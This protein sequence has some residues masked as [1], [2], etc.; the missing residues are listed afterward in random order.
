MFRTHGLEV[1]SEGKFEAST[2][3]GGMNYVSRVAT[4]GMLRV[5]DRLNLEDLG[6]PVRT[7]PIG[8]IDGVNDLFGMFDRAKQGFRLLFQMNK[9]RFDEIDP[10]K[11]LSAVGVSAEDEAA[12]LTNDIFPSGKLNQPNKDFSLSVAM[13][14]AS[15]IRSLAQAE[16]VNFYY[17]GI[18]PTTDD[19]TFILTPSYWKINLSPETIWNTI[20]QMDS[21][22]KTAV[23][24]DGFVE[25][26]P[27][28]YKAAHFLGALP[29]LRIF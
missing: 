25:N 3:T 29:L 18:I 9:L 19:P 27:V 6:I 11:F 5:V 14:F 15:T 7:I 13:A 16:T 21:A 28:L 22:V 10:E 26:T 20:G 23:L 2:F 24:Q 17:L 8:G 4:D 1:Y 12:R